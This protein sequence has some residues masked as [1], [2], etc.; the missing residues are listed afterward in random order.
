MDPVMTIATWKVRA[1]FA[2]AVLCVLAFA[3]TALA[4]SGGG[5]GMGPPL[6][7]GPP[8]IVGLQSMQVPGAKFTI[9][10]RVAD[11]TPGSCTVT[12]TGA[13]NATALCDSGGNFSVTVN[14]PVLGLVTVVASDGQLSSDPAAFNLANAAP[15]T[16]VTAI[17][18][19][20]N[21]W[22]IGG[23]VG[24]EAP[25]GLTVTLSGHPAVRGRTATVLAN[26]NWSIT[27]TM[28]SFGIVNA[29]VTDWYG[30]TGTAS[31][32]AG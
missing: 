2:A 1:G 22:T 25:L 15:T 18:G 19:F 21:N 16:T 29:S 24:D 27:V 3:D 23:T 5:G 32:P 14:V 12:F 28:T 26:G 6:P 17:H 11:E 30:L 20:G 10:G 31:T 7:N 13:A 9:S 4:Q 8:M